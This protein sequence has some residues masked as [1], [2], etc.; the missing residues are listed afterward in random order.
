MTDIIKSAVGLAIWL[1][2]FVI[3][4][5]FIVISVCGLLA[6]LAYLIDWAF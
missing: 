4:L 2:S 1:A 6:A 3:T 5:A